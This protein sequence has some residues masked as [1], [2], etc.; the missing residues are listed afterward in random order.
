MK[1]VLLIANG[2][3]S[4]RLTSNDVLA[5]MRSWYVVTM[6]ARDLPGHA[7]CIHDSPVVHR[8]YKERGDDRRK[9]LCFRKHLPEQKP[10]IY[11]GWLELPERLDGSCCGRAA[12]VWASESGADEVLLL[13]YDGALDHRTIGPSSGGTKS[14]HAAWCARMVEDAQ[15]LGNASHPLDALP[16]ERV[17]VESVLAEVITA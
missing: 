9:V 3:S 12:F 14:Q 6:N 8:W 2:P 10:E 13:G 5:L 11:H 16:A 7:V 4:W 15:G 17:S 1:P